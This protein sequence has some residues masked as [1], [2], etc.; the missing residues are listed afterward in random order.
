VIS[1]FLAY[2]IGLIVNISSDRLKKVY[3][4][5]SNDNV[6]QLENIFYESFIRAIDEHS[7]HY[8]QYAKDV[9]KKLKL[10]IKQDKFKFID[11][12]YNHSEGKNL[13]FIMQDEEF[14]KTVAHQIVSTYLIDKESIIE[15]DKIVLDCL[16]YYKSAFFRYMSE[17]EGIIAILQN[18]LELRNEIDQIKKILNINFNIKS[19][20]IEKYDDYKNAIINNFKEINFFGLGLEKHKRKKIR[21][22]QRIYVKPRFKEV[23]SDYFKTL[24]EQFR[25]KFNEDFDFFDDDDDD[26]DL[27]FSDILNIISENRNIV[28]LG[29]PGAGKSI[30]VKYIMYLLADGNREE[31]SNKSIYEYI[32]FRIELR[33]YIKEKRNNRCNIINYMESLIKL[34]YQIDLSKISNLQEFFCSY[35]TLI[36]FDGLDE[37]FDVNEKTDIRNDIH[38]FLNNYKNA[39]A[40][41]TSRIIGYDEA[42]FDNSIFTELRILNFN[43][44]QMKQYINKWYCQDCEVM[45]SCEGI[46]KSME[47]C[48]ENVK[49]NISN[50]IDEIDELEDEM[51][52]NPLLLSLI[53]ILYQNNGQ[54]PS[55]KLELYKSCTKT[56]VDNWDQTK[57]DLDININ[58]ILKRRKDNIFSSLALWQYMESSKES[59]VIE[60][61]NRSVTNQVLETIIKLELTDDVN[62]AEKWASEFMDYAEKRSLYFDN[63]FTHKTF[64]EYYTALRIFQEYYLKKKDKLCEL[65]TRYVSNS[66][67][68]NV[69]ELLFKMIDEVQCD[70]NE[71]RELIDKVTKNNEGAY[72]FFLKNI[73]NMTNVSNK[74]IV[75]LIKSA[76]R[77]CIFKSSFSNRQNILPQQIFY[78]MLSLSQKQVYSKEIQESFDAIY[79]EMTDKELIYKYLILYYELK[80]FF[81]YANYLALNNN[82]EIE[83]L[84]K[85]STRIFI[86]DYRISSEDSDLTKNVLEFKSIFGIDELFKR[87]RLLYI[88]GT[89]MS[90]MEIYFGKQFE[91]KNIDSAVTNVKKLIDAGVAIEQ[92]KRIKEYRVIIN[93]KSNIEMFLKIINT[94]DDWEVISIILY[95]YK[96]ILRRTVK[97]NIELIKSIYSE[98]ILND[99]ILNYISELLD[100]EYNFF[101]DINEI[102]E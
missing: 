74:T 98:H 92:F 40:I 58:D 83:I 22:M 69:M 16:S 24:S 21:E 65:V 81:S 93:L 31:F 95:A 19:S 97:E 50:L 36:F 43:N 101:N 84:K 102:A 48:S 14:R 53:I 54:L 23:N 5:F 47:H 3:E 66:F 99:K 82:Q 2:P 60:I 10:G 15:I 56:L 73:L 72:P 49:D 8:D 77:I 4:N 13:L 26:D 11:M 90:L 1:S 33:K 32:P 68:F 78:Q 27:D 12:F 6:E 20:F 46:S 9:T 59:N 80:S 94:T 96:R 86:E 79:C 88:D 100:H 45:D 51:K 28:I 17:K 25:K 38:N 41:V 75:N 89:R 61:N 67:W 34:E 35:N 85:T 30:L 44:N 42:R 29:D 55:S 64:W 62:E 70:N 71:I 63:N 76:M 7:K 57:I 52:R 91:C 18:S 37:I 39:K 87:S